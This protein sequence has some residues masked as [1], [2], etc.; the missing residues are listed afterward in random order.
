MRKI[1]IFG[2][3]AA[4][5]LV[6]VGLVGVAIGQLATPVPT[7]VQPFAPWGSNANPNVAA[8]YCYNVTGGVP[9]YGVNGAVLGYCAGPQA[10]SVYG[11]GGQGCYG[12]GAQ[13]PSQ[14]WFGGMMG[15][16]GM[17]GRGW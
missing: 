6:S 16:R 7:A 13:V 14:G 5:A 15:G 4:L 8:P 17:L 9:V 2:I 3:I 12:Y 1:T 11:Y 10:Q